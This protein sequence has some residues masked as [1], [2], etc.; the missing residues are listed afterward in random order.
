M[1]GRSLYASGIPPGECVIK[2]CGEEASIPSD[3]AAAARP[4]GIVSY[5]QNYQGCCK[6]DVLFCYDLE[7]PAE[8]VPE[9]DD[10]E[11]RPQLKMHEQTV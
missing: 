7:L 10:G 3:L 11:V 9:P 2:E 8:F 6:R 4:V 1:A 5:V